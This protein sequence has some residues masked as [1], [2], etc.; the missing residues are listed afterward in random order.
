M[1]VLIGSTGFVG[2]H[3]GAQHRFDLALH[4]PTIESLTGQ[5]VDLL[6]CAGLPAAK[7]IANSE[8]L[9]DWQNMAGLAQVLTTVRAARPVL[10]ST[11]DVFQP[12][13]DVDERSAVAFAGPG[14]YGANR[15]WFEAFFQWRFPN[16]TV[17]RLPGLFASD[18]RKNLIFDFKEGREDQYSA[19]NPT[20]RFQFFDASRTWE[21]V[22]RATHHGIR[23]LNVASEPVTAQAV[24]DL[25][26][27]RLF[28]ESEPIAYDM[29]S[30]HADA[31]G[32]RDGYLYSRAEVLS[33][34]GSACAGTAR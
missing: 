3:L 22:Q 23:L 1:D 12:P 9:A 20:S 25:F 13:V 30:L 24:A 19:M 34:I 7:W 21:V 28:G 14:A 16:A 18:L 5:D 29:R 11:I 27:V 31:F 8:P 10:I 6:V 32:G 15:A 2:G 26:G 33:G 4:R 17:V